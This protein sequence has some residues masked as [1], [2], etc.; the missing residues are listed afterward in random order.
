MTSA[1]MHGEKRIDIGRKL[2]E[3]LVSSLGSESLG[4]TTRPILHEPELGTNRAM[5]LMLGVGNN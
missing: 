3:K 4:L 5:T 2:I 1:Q